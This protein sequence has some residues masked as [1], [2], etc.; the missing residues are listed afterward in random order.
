VGKAE[1]FIVLEIERRADEARSHGHYKPQAISKTQ[2]AGKLP[3]Y[4]HYPLRPVL[5]LDNHAARLIRQR[6]PLF[7]LAL[8]GVD[9]RHCR[10]RQLLVLLHHP[11]ISS[12]AVLVREASWR[13]SSATTAKPRPCS[14]ARAASMAAL[15][16]SRLV[17]P[18][19]S[20]M[21]LMIEPITRDWV[22]SAWIP[23]AAS[24][25]EASSPRIT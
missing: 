10:L 1:I 4:V 13:T 16:A 15:S 22:S 11:A 25:I 23:S 19:M 8:A 17:C 24:C 12:V 9:D 20:L 3:H 14:P 21:V 6:Q 18:A 2:P 7:G 5:D